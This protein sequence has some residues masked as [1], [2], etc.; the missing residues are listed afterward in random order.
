MKEILIIAEYIGKEET[1]Q[2]DSKIVDFVRAAR[3]TS[4]IY[5]YT[6]QFI[7]NKYGE[8]LRTKGVHIYSI[9]D[10]AL[11]PQEYDKIVATDAWAK[12]VARQFR[13]RT[14]D[15]PSAPEHTPEPMSQV[16]QKQQEK[17]DRMTAEA[18]DLNYDSTTKKI[19]DIIIPHHNRHDL[20]KHLLSMIPND[21]FNIH[22]ISGK[23]FGKNCN[24]GAKIAET[25]NLIFL[26][27]DIEI[28]AEQLIK[29][30]NSLK[31]YDFV[32]TTQLAGADQ[33]KYWGI[34][35]FQDEKGQLRHGISDLEKDSIFPSGFCFAI[36]KKAWDSLKGFNEKYSTGNEDIDLGFRAIDKKLKMTI[37]DLEIPHMESQSLGRFNFVE[38]NE[39]L[40]YKTWGDKLE[41]Y[42][43]IPSLSD[44]DFPIG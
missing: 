40:F 2:N 4:E 9:T 18:T 26:N 25:K 22:I 39:D 7:L 35:V 19:A 23:S 38:E 6:K 11:M 44:D 28:T 30:V 36:T 10:L 5:F 20:L 27:D 32:G 17:E 21:I 13:V 34:K 37:L 31:K 42:A 8:Y 29:M 41:K 16:V 33:K 12:T 43:N 24:K 3:D 15:Q 14:T 1:E